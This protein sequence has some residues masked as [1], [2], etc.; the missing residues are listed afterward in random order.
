MDVQLRKQIASCWMVLNG[1]QFIIWA[2]E[3]ITVGS[4]YGMYN[5][6]LNTHKMQLITCSQEHNSG[7][8]VK[9]KIWRKTVE[10][11]HKESVMLNLKV[12]FL[13]AWTKCWKNSGVASAL[14]WHNAYVT[15]L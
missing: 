7:V 2:W 10:S 13:L 1:Y 4:Y 11:P 5:S 14:K 15:S 8:F 3:H 6:L 9:F 12:F